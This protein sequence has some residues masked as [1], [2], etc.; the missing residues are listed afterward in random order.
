VGGAGHH[1][2]LDMT[3]LSDPICIQ[4]LDHDGE[5]NCTYFREI[6]MTCNRTL[7]HL[8]WRMISKLSFALVQ[9]THHS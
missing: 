5:V 1:V 8:G 2:G 3:F 7:M 9:V 4:A 6:C